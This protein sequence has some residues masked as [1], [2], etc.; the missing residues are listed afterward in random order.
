MKKLFV[1]VPLLWLYLL[2]GAQLQPDKTYMSGIA[3]IKFFQYGNQMGYPIITLGSTNSLE[4]H[5][6]ELGT[7][8]KNYSYT[9]QLCNADWKPVELSEMDYIDGFLQNRLN[10]YR[11]SS[12]ANVKY[13]HYQAMFP[14]KNSMP[15]KAGNYILKVFLNGDTSKLAFTRRMLVVNNSVPIGVTIKQ[16]YNS[17]AVR[18]HQKVQFTINVTSLNIFNPQQQLKVVVLQNY[19]WDNAITGKQPVFMRGNNY[20]YNGEQDFLFPAGKEYRWLNLK[21]FRFLSERIDHIDKDSIPVDVYLKP[22]LDRSRDRILMLQDYD[23]MFEVN[24]TDANNPW[25]QGD[26]GHVHFTYVPSGNQPFM[27]KDVYIMGEMAGNIANDS[28]RLTYNAT[29]GVYEKTLFLKQGYYNY[30]YVTKDKRVKNAP[31]ETAYTEGDYWE[32]QNTYTVLVYY[33]SLSGR[34]DELL[35]ATSINSRTFLKGL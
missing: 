25:W 33:R 8:I 10:Q 23:G 6:D 26:Y 1:T 4:L 14:V 9:Y 5:F 12:I 21:S 16:P 15:S 19:K 32:T 29:K 27:D 17:A 13:I 31:I 24:C 2:A 34:A 11:I 28:T 30:Q 20:E 22:D 35:G 18:T 3:G 7:T